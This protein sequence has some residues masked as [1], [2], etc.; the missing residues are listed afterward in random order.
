M[1]VVFELYASYNLAHT[2]HSEKNYHRQYSL[3]Y[4]RMFRFTSIV[5]K[6]IL[7]KNFGMS[8][9]LNLRFICIPRY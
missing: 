8:I 7:P 9:K 3:D 1:E 6:L 5:D 4:M 2:L